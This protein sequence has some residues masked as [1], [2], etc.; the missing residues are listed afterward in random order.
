MSS[1]P[2]PFSHMIP[3]G[4]LPTR[5]DRILVAEAAPEALL[6]VAAALG[7][8]KVASLKLEATISGNGRKGWRVAGRLSAEV[9]QACVVT[10][11]PMHAQ[12]EEVVE[13]SFVEDAAALNTD[14]LEIDIDPEDD[15]PPELLGDGIDL[16][17]IAVEA[18]ALALDP[19][20]RTPG[21]AFDGQ[22]AAPP[23][24]EPLTDEAVKPFAGLAKLKQSME[25]GE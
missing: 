25:G 12:I 17:A 2:P 19:Y 14:E 3:A 18:L 6:A 10:L 11:A 23:G 24:A 20:P 13:R 15:D 7:V 8:P 5:T 22:V 4:D 16:G 21:A 9:E 1:G